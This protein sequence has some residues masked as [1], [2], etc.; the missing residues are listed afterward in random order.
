MKLENLIFFYAPE[1]EKN[2]RKSGKR[3]FT[4]KE[5]VVVTVTT[6]RAEDTDL[7]LFNGSEALF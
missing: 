6:I 7:K 3:T 1:M 2:N 5:G 4:T